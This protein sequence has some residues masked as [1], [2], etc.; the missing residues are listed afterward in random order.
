MITVN[1]CQY[2][3]PDPVRWSDAIAAGGFYYSRACWLGLPNPPAILFG[4]GDSE[5]YYRAMGQYHELF[6]RAESRI[7]S[8]GIA[9]L[10]GT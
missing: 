2:A 10:D 7:I 4:P 8:G 9:D 3:D 1:G 5:A 6:R